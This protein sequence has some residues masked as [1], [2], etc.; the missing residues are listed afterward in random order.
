VIALL[1]LLGLQSVWLY[2]TYQLTLT[3]IKHFINNS[4]VESMEKELNYRFLMAGNINSSEGLE[5]ASFEYN[6]DEIDDIGVNSLMFH[7]A[8]LFTFEMGLPFDLI[9]LDSLYSSILQQNHLP[10][11]HQLIY[12]DSLGTTIESIGKKI[13]NGFKT[14]SISIINGN[15]VQA[16]VQITVPSVFRNMLEILIASALLF[17]L[18]IGCLIYEIK[19]FLT[20]HHLIQLR[21]NFSNA[22]THDMKTPL[23]TIYSILDISNKGALDSNPEM[24]I[25]FNTIATEQ[26]LN[27]QAI[28]NRIL[29]LAYIDKKQLN[30]D[31]QRLDLPKMIESLIDKFMI[32]GGKTIYFSKKFNL[33][34]VEIYAD[35]FYIE[36]AISNLLDNAIKYSDESIKIDIECTAGDKQVYIKVKDNGFGISSDDQLKIFERFERGAEIKRKQVSGFGLGLNYVKRVIEAHGGAIALSSREG[37]GS[38]FIITIPIELTPIENDLIQN[39]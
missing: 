2:N 4:F 22:L 16:N 38:E 19:M 39:L 27:L 12:T 11:K 24:R 5:I 1:F 25:K 30:L 20:Q 35:P 8:Q 6:N 26:I 23:S 14:N 34:N 3:E 31:K 7:S 21:D 28:I 17:L 32:K 10:L 36:N 13:E 18:I 37:I 9:Y 29:T 33:K 15:K